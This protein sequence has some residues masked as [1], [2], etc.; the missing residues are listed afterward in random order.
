MA[1]SCVF[2]NIAAGGVG[3]NV[4]YRDELVTA[5]R[6]LNP[7]APTHILVIP[8]EHV[9]SIA[10]IGDHHPTLVLR[11]MVVANRIAATEGLDGGYR[12]VTNVGTDAGQ[13]VMHLHFHVLGGRKMAWPPG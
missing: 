7:Q 4:V 13:S 2:C 3:A 12:L 11:M 6:D 5:F 10:H 1:E 8:N 9:E